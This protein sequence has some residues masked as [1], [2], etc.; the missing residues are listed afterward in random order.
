M[1]QLMML[2]YWVKI[3]G[4]GRKT[5]FRSEDTAEKNRDIFMIRQKTGEKITT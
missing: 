4:L 2:M 5:Q 3:K 1:Y